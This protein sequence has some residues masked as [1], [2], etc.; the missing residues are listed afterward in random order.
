MAWIYLMKALMD[1]S[2]CWIKG[3]V[4]VH[5]RNSAGETAAKMHRKLAGVGRFPYYDSKAILEI[6]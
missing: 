1:E 5:M 3:G 4:V 6:Y 2:R